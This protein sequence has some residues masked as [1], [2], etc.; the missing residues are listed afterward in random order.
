MTLTFDIIENGMPKTFENFL[1]FY[2][3]RSGFICVIF[4]SRSG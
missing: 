3:G 2:D 4:G 1:K